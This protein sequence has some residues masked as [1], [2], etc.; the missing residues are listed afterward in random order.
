MSN[1]AV[2]DFP[3][4]KTSPISWPLILM[5]VLL[6]LVLGVALE[7]PVGSI[8]GHLALEQEGFNLYTYD[9][10][11][12]H[13]YAMAIGP[14]GSAQQERAVWVKEDGSFRID[15]LP[16]GEYEL[17]VHVPGFATS[18]DSGIFVEKNQVTALNHDIALELSKPSVRIGAQ[19]SVFTTKQPPHFWINAEGSSQATVK[20]FKRDMKGLLDGLIEAKKPVNAG[21]K[22]GFEINSDLSVYKP[23]DEASKG[24]A[25]QFFSAM[26]PVRVWE[27][28]LNSNDSDYSHQEFKFENPLPP[29]DYFALAQ[30][31]NAQNKTDWN[32]MWFCVTDVG[33]IVKQDP[34]QTLVRAIDLNTLQPRAGYNLHLFSRD[35]TPLQQLSSAKTG[36]DGFA[37][38]K[39]S[40]TLT[41]SQNLLVYGGNADEHAY[42]SFGFYNGASDSALT[43]FYTDRPVYRLGQVVYYKGIVR[44]KNADGFKNPGSGMNVDVKVEDPDN[45]E[46]ATDHIRTSG[47]G[48]FHGIASIPKDGKTGAY[49]L[50]FTY[51][52]GSQDFERF[53]VAEYRKPEYQVDVIPL[54]PRVVAGQKIRARIKAAY[55]FGAP[56]TNAK[57]KYSVYSGIDWS[58]RYNLM[59]R[60]AYYGYFDGWDHEDEGYSDSGYGGDYISEGTAQTD[61]NGEAI[62]EIDTKRSTFEADHPWDYERYDRTY[63]IQAEV[64]DISRLAVIGS[65]GVSVTGGEFGMFLKADSYVAK[66]GDPIGAELTAVAYNDHKPVANQAIKVQ[67]YRRKYDRNRGEYKGVDI[68]ED[69]TVTTDAKGHAHV[70]FK[71]KPEFVTDDYN[72]IA[73]AEDNQHNRIVDESYIWIVSDRYPYALNANDAQKEAL[74]IKLDKEV[75]K[76][77]DTAKV[78]ITAP[79]TGKEGAQAIVS[80]EGRKLYSYQVVNMTATGRM[81][82][83]PLKVDYAPNVFVSVVFVGKG[84]QFY[85]QSQMVRVSPE[86]RFLHV[87]VETDKSK[88]R[89]G[90]TATYTLTAKYADGKPAANTELS[91]SLVDESIYA[92]RPDSTQDIRK[93]FYRRQENMVTTMCSF[94]EEYSGG[95]NKIEPRVRKDFKD[96]AAWLPELI[97]DKNGVVVTKVKLPDNLTTWRATVRGITMNTDVG[98][99]VQKVISTQDLILRLALP[100]FFSQ[101]DE[102]SITAVV[103]NYTD[104]PQAVVLTLSPST[105]FRVKDSLVQKIIV[106]PDKAERFSWPV[107]VMDAG[108]AV[109]RCKAVGDTAGDAMETKLPVLPLGIEEAV[110]K[111]GLVTAED[112]TIKIQAAMPPDA[113]PGTVKQHIY[114]SSSALGSVLGNF[115]K[116][117]DY[118]YGCTEQTMSKLMPSIVAIRMNQTLGLPLTKEDKAKFGDVYKQSMQKLDGYQHDDGG[119]GWWANDDSNMNLTALV[120][121]GYNLLKAS[122]YAVDPTRAENGKKWLVQGTDTLFKQL[123]DPKTKTDI[124]IETDRLIDM[125][126]AYYVLSQYGAKIPAKVVDWAMARKDRMTPETLAYLSMALEKQGEHDR[127]MMLYNRLV[128]L[129][130]V[131]TG[132][133]GSMLDWS[134]SKRMF[135]MLNPEY[136]DKWYIYSYRYT[137]VETTALALEALLAIDPNNNDRIEQIKRWILL[138]RGKDGWDNTKTTSQV[139]RS[140][141]DCEV[142]QRKTDGGMPT[143]DADV[144]TDGA[145]AQHFSF[146]GK[147]VLQP[148]RDIVIA[149]K[150]GQ[151]TLSIHKKGGG[152]LYY[153]SLTTYYRAIKPGQ[154]VAEKS[155]PEGLKLRREFLRL[156]PSKPDSEGNVTFTAQPLLNNTVKAGETVLMKVYVDS[157]TS[158]PYT[159]LKAPLPSGAEVVEND[160]R[161]N[162]EETNEDGSAK[163]DEQKDAYSWGSWWWTHQDVMDDHLAFF[164][165]DFARGKCEFHQMVRLELPGKYQLNPVYLEGMYTKAVRAHSQADVL[166]VTE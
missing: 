79:V 112:D 105:Q 78:M 140:L 165:T 21:K 89:P 9:M 139:F 142:A 109:V 72:I 27:R 15:Q 69:V 88:Y 108:D 57:V 137:D 92:I 43:Y 153:T 62:V 82:E 99:V 155:N 34:Y 150:P 12:H 81:V 59:D 30:V 100:R 95:P 39:M 101:G 2:E 158:V 54:E 143:F 6:L 154:F 11:G 84:H 161:E 127:A 17:K 90:E 4:H 50:T 136:H 160:S 75:Y 147:S 19:T 145:V 141:M 130:N 76:A 51:P 67:L 73:I 58:G 146:D 104:K 18:Y 64:T 106:Y 49:Q 98:S 134:P 10:R 166:T 123:T 71:T 164:V 120:L 162:A 29:G 118:P 16:V 91:M 113:V 70:Q 157:P 107:T 8:S 13:V 129:G 47:H 148:E 93:F 20:V 26:Q 24:K 151:N 5:K 48:S 44:K 131:T 42:G 28:E 119:W 36:A 114:L 85:Q 60:P 135:S 80:V 56:V 41:S 77:G 46:I 121:D 132:D 3:M 61:A 35:S 149:M 124:W 159:F 55:Y 45:Q 110:A 40:E 122:G 125:G 152:K 22:Y 7:K 33:L 38:M 144:L 25:V 163:T 133:T 116:L 66:V 103:H 1:A 111:S 74:T 52:D 97:T 138:Q 96:T 37:T 115:H 68:Y 31:K 32:L 65:G 128:E 156:V 86:D 102:G 53:E 23:Y 14:R 83:I 126:K 87:D 94:P 63:K 117:I